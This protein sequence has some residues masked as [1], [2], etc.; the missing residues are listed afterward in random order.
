[1]TPKS[2]GSEKSVK[3]MQI[4]WVWCQYWHF[5]LISKKYTSEL[6]NK[7]GLK[8]AKFISLSIW[9]QVCHYHMYNR[10]IWNHKQ[11]FL[12]LQALLCTIVLISWIHFLDQ[13]SIKRGSLLIFMGCPPNFTCAIF[14]GGT[15]FSKPIICLRISIIWLFSKPTISQPY[16]TIRK[17]IKW[18]KYNCRSVGIIRFR[19]RLN[20]TWIT[21][22]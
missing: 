1:M 22:L 3:Q 8:I 18:G 12:V 20:S 17:I 13:K 7:W 14:I 19:F 16:N 21:L 10:S 6:E 5:R 2:R 9:K 15:F 11:H 4:L